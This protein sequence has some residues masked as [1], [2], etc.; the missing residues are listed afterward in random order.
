MWILRRA[1]PILLGL[2]YIVSPIDAIPDFIP[3]VGWLDDLFVLGFLVWYLGS[4]QRG[5]SPW[6]WLR[7]RVGGPRARRPDSPRPEDLTADFSGMD[8]YALLEVSRNATAEELRS[9]Y[10]RAVTRYHPDKVAH[11]GP[12]FQELAHKKLL[13]IQQAYETLQGKRR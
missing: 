13:A 3:G 12:E 9:A 2:V 1:L 11:L 8:P 6:E 10:R 4:Q 7:G 5:P